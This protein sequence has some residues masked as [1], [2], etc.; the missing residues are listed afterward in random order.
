MQQYIRFSENYNKNFLIPISES[1]YKYIKNHNLPHFISMMKYNHDQFLEWQKTD[2]LKGMKDSKTTRIWADFDSR[3]NLKQ[4]FVD[5]KVFVERLFELGFAEDEVQISFSGSKGTGVIVETDSEFTI[6]QVQNI[7]LNLSKGLT[8]FDTGMYDHQRIF[9]LLFTKNEKTGLYKIP[10]SFNELDYDIE[11]IKEMARDISDMD[12][13]QVNAYYKRSSVKIKPELLTAPVKKVDKKVTVANLI[14]TDTKPRHYKE[15]K[16]QIMQGNFV[17]GERQNALMVLAATC[18]GVGYL[19]PH[20]TALLKTADKLHCE[21]VGRTDTKEDDIDSNI[22]P[23]VYS[24]S[25]K[26]GQYS[27][28]NNKW[29]QEYCERLGIK[30]E[31]D[32]DRPIIRI[33]DV[34]TDFIDYM[35]NIE[36]NTVKTGIDCLDKAMPLTTGMICGVVGAPSS[37]K[38]ALALKMLKNTSNNDV[39]SVF[40]SL[41]MHRTRLFQKLVMSGTNLNRDELIK[42]VKAGESN[43]IFEQIEKDYRNVF[44]YDRSA[45]SVPE[46]RKYIERVQEQTN[47]RVRFLMIDYFERL[48]SDRSDDTAASKEVAGALQDLCNDFNLCIVVLVQPNKMSLGGGPDSPILSYTAIKGSSFLYQAFRSI[49]SIWRPFFTPGTKHNDNYMSM[50]ILKNDLGELDLFDF[51]WSGRMGDIW[52]LNDDGRDE[53]KRLLQE[54]EGNK[55]ESKGNGWLD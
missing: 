5:C 9:R 50:A 22:I 4:A 27:P 28:E 8:T 52:E 39:L 42:S 1:P 7:C 43:D 18:R 26:G 17:P 15:Y 48:G 37:G 35:E 13:D 19:A 55:A 2:S 21:R 45:A 44:F 32:E 30:T 29:L 49:I 47:K 20:A 16:W 38:T 3:E 10:L 25:W 41:D 14:N 36:A 6:D 31:E 23:S 54:K 33:G 34:K 12:R 24:E 51:G 46:I 53:L 11:A 40:A